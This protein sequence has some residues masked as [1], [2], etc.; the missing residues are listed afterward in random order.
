MKFFSLI[1]I[2]PPGVNAK[3]QQV[4]L[5]DIWP[6]REEIQAVERQ[7]VIPGMFKEVYQ[8]IEVRSRPTRPQVAKGT[9]LLCV[10][11]EDLEAS[12]GVNYRMWH[13]FLQRTKGMV[14]SHFSPVTHIFTNPPHPRCSQIWTSGWQPQV[15]RPRVVCDS[16][17]ALHNSPFLTWGV[18]SSVVEDHLG[19]YHVSL[20]WSQLVEC[21]SQNYLDAL[22]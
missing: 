18:A 8:K 13:V 12:G 21:T 6:T 15:E 16:W 3:G 20:R 22:E 7:Y 19:Y 17:A 4:F 2:F 10:I 1:N 9:P 11:S 5:K 14:L